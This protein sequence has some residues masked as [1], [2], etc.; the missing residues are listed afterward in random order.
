MSDTTIDPKQPRRL[1]KKTNMASR[2]AWRSGYYG[3]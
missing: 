2:T 3:S 1:E